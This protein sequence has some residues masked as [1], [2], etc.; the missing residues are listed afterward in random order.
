MCFPAAASDAAEPD[1]ASEEAMFARL[2]RFLFPLVLAASAAALAACSDA[3]MLATHSPAHP[4]TNGAVTLKAHSTGN[5]DKITLAYEVYTLSTGAGGA[6]VQTLTTAMTDVKT[7][8]PSGNV[9]TLDCS[10]TVTSGFAANRLIKFKATA[11]GGNG[12]TR[13]ESYFFAAGTYPWPN[14]P[15]PIRVTGDPATHMDVVFIPDTDI[16]L[17]NFR[18]GLAA[19][20]EDLY[21]KYATYR[22]SDSGLMWRTIYNFYYSG[23]QGN[24]EETCSFTAPS[25]LSTLQATGDAI[26]ILHQTTLRDC[27][28]GGMFSSEINYDKTLIHETGHALFDLKDEYCCDS[29]YSQ[30]ACYPNLYASKAACEADAPSLGLQASDCVRLTNGTTTLNF[31]RVD[32]TAAPGCMMGPSQHTSDS[33]HGPADRRRIDWRRAGCLGGNC[34]PAC[35][36]P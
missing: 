30:Q 29:S 5:V 3:S 25:N 1:T 36:A 22:G 20:I 2:K 12:K 24:Y 28:S 4:G 31:W 21:F 19:V 18:S 23:V 35:P 15:I 32:P 9:S 16:T 27:K 33:D 34:F 10:F 26:A 17:A 8:D 6:H 14:D 11:R 7:C 13:S